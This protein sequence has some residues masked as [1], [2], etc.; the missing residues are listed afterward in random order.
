MKRMGSIY[1]YVN[2]D[3]LRRILAGSLRFTQPSAF[4]D[5]FELLPEIVMPAGEKERPMPL[6]FDI[7]AQ[8][9]NPPVGEVTVVPDG[10]VSSDPTS[11]D[12]VAQLNSVIGFSCLSTSN[13]SLLMWSHY[14]DQYAG[15]VIEFDAAH[16]F[17]A[18]PIDIEYR[19]I[20]PKR[21]LD[22]YLTG[23]PIP[24]SELCVKSDQWRC[25]GEVRIVRSLADCESN[26]KSD[27]RGFP[28]YTQS[29]PIE[30]IKSVTLGE[31][32]SIEAQREIY[33][34]VKDTKVALALAAVDL[35]G[36]GFRREIIK[37][38][39][40]ISQMGPWMSPRTAHIFR[41]LPNQRGEFARALIQ[42]H[43]LSKI[44][45]KPV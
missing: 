42:V 3:G 16:E 14:A 36:Y 12:I 5:P 20:R 10:Y 35:A 37:Y 26:G 17:F 7:L 27:S 23:E 21:H 6:R 28:I 32:M 45:N 31:R 34:R 41:D 39:V 15:A 38:P 4:N 2:L 30:A 25:E 22:V 13:D 29:L 33:D 44:V 8:R 40:P 1:K 11:R 19:A 18:H 43:P 9:R 24:L